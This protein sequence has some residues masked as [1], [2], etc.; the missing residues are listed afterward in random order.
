[1]DLQVLLQKLKS[2]NIEIVMGLETHIRLNTASK[3][4]CSCS[5]T[6]SEIP[7]TH[8]CPVCTGQMGSLPAINKE[9]VRKAV[10]FGK[11]VHS[12]LKNKVVCWDRK[13]YEYPDL[14]KNY[15][16]TQFQKPIIPDGYISCYRNDGSVFTVELE[17]VHIEEDAA[18]LIHEQNHTLVDFNK[19]GVPLI[20]VV[21]KPCLHQIADV[22]IYAQN[23]QRI[24]QTLRI[25]N[26]NLEKGEFKSD[27]SVSLR[28]AGTTQLNPRAEIKNLNSFKFMAEAIVDEVEKQLEYYILHNAFRPDQTTVLFDSDAK[29]TRTM[30]KKEYAADYRFALDPDTPLVNISGLIEATKIDEDSMPFAIETVMINAG[31]RP[32]DAKFFTSDAER[33]AVFVALDSSLKDPLFVA[34]TL[35]NN[36]KI[37]DYHAIPEHLEAVTYLFQSYRNQ[38]ISVIVL[39]EALQHLF[40]EQSFDYRSFIASKSISDQDLDDK[41]N[42]AL[43][44]YPSLVDEIKGGNLSRIGIL[45][46]NVIKATGKAVSGKLVKQK[47]IDQ[48]TVTTP[49]DA[50]GKTP[51][52]K[53]K[54]ESDAIQMKRLQETVVVKERYRTHLISDISISNL[55]EEVIL[56]GWVASVRDHGE[57]IFIDLR[58]SSQE[59]FQVRVTRERLSNFDDVA[60]LPNESVIMVSGSIIKRNPED[61]NPKIRTGEIEIDAKQIDVLNLSNPLPFEIRKTDKVTEGVRLRYKFL[62]HR[63]PST[64][65]AI[66]NRHRVLHLIRE[67]LNKHRFIEIETPI[68]SAGTD[69]GAREFIVPSRRFPGRFYSLPQSPQQYKQMLMVSGF[70]RYFQ[71]ARCFRDEDSR[72]DRQAEFTQLDLEM[73]F[74]NMLDVMDLNTKLFN[75]IITTIYPQEWKLFPFQTLTYKEAMDKYGSDRPDLRFPLTME[76][77]TDIVKK[78]SFNVFAKPIREGGIVKCIKVPGKLTDKRLTK[79]QIEKLTELAQQNGLG[80]LAYIIVNENDLQSPIIKYLGEDICREILDRMQ[81]VVGDIIFFSAADYRTANN[82]LCAVRLELGKMLNLIGQKELHPAWVIDFPQYEKTDEGNWTFSHNPFS[83]PKPECIRDHINGINLEQVLSQQYDLV[84]NGYEI[85][86]GSIRA[87]K[88]EILEA[89]YRNMGYDEQS[90]QKSIGHML[91]AF[92]YGAPPHGGIAWGIDRLMMILENKSSIREVMAFPKTGSGEEILFGSPTTISNKKILEANIDIKLKVES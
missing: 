25:S 65:Q 2:L 38:S 47:I 45:V 29:Q 18:K 89:T 24:V 10:L 84:L 27:V 64:H 92:R 5:N 76:D 75:K 81:T 53:S 4:F 74:V 52:A 17:Q 91:E 67:T 31:V 6:E 33:S 23:L 40:E 22:P 21:T 44:L 60:K 7:N 71:I 15:Q 69:E 50:S 78:T 79:S 88:K 11:A 12:S 73:S 8:I 30:R 77:I 48:L 61:Y 72:G 32:Q 20:E 83:M 59:V 14:P 35:V 39:Q 62:D 41:I 58:D 80:G 9:A 28:K 82:A 66:V 86:G 57:L 85:G 3:L 51:E 49:T 68:L 1:M 34:K 55:L 37:E 36:V 26:A 70:D 56:A 13:H 42:E 43:A 90:M 87:H 16:L 19:S 46:G 63:N 54:S